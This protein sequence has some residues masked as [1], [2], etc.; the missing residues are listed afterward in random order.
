MAVTSLINIQLIFQM[1][2][3]NLF[4]L[5]TGLLISACSSVYKPNGAIPSYLSIL[6]DSTKIRILHSTQNYLE[7]CGNSKQAKM[8]KKKGIYLLPVTVINNSGSAVTF[9]T[10]N[11]KIYSN[12][13]QVDILTDDECFKSLNYSTCA[14]LCWFAGGAVGSISSTNKGTTFNYKSPMMLLFVP[15]VIFLARDIKSNKA[16]QADISKRYLIGKPIQAYEKL[17]GYICIR[18]AHAENIQI[19]IIE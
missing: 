10:N 16:L 13:E 14:K 18:A 19:R 1:R 2:K 15:G 4:L 8:G 7:L 12:Y 17:E 3:T 9:T 5:F 11:L 6:S